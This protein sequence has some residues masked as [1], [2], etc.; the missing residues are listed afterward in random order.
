MPSEWYNWVS[1]KLSNGKCSSDKKKYWLNRKL[2]ADKKP[3]FM[4]YIYPSEKTKMSEYIKRN[5]EKCIMKFR[6]TLDELLKKE[7]L[8]QD[9]KKFISCYYCYSAN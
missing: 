2:V 7:L 9:E 6:I 3:Y 8:T 1:N 4:Q 5:N